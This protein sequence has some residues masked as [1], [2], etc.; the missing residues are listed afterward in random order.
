[1]K[2]IFLSVAMAL[3]LSACGGG[4]G[5]VNA[6]NVG[7]PNAPVKKINDPSP[8]ASGPAKP[9]YCATTYPAPAGC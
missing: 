7:D 5:D 4:E 9:A 6:S 8:T 1:M 3:A 2:A